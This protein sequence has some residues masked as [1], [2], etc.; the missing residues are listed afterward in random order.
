MPAEQAVTQAYCFV[1]TA[2]IAPV[3]CSYGKDRLQQ[4][5]R[6]C[7]TRGCPRTS[8][9][10]CRSTAPIVVSMLIRQQETHEITAPFHE[11]KMVDADHTGCYM[12]GQALTRFSSKLSELRKTLFAAPE[13]VPA[14]SRAASIFLSVI[15]AGFCWMASP[16]RR[17]EVASP[18]A[19]MI[20]LC[21]SCSALSTC[22]FIIARRLR[23]CPVHV[24]RAT[25]IPEI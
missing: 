25:V 6:G 24:W 16:I 3:E 4:D 11:H 8:N 2:G 13:I 10:P 15:K 9:S 22:T 14:M 20:A 23:T 21:L 19:L 5:Q 7:F 18:C 17:A 1:S 12:P